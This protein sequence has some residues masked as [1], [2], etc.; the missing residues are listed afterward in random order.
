VVDASAVLAVLQLEAGAEVVVDD[1]KDAAIS[2]VN[3]TEVATK[4]VDG[5]LSVA[6]ARYTI[7]LLGMDVETFD[8]AQAYAA[9][10]M[11]IDT[12]RDGLSAGDRACLALGAKLG[13]TVLTADKAWKAVKAGV[14]VKLIR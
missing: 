2:A 9:A 14:D 12:R 5:G 4:L 13:A 10:A 3:V 1:L 7:G 8:E 6:D 11:R